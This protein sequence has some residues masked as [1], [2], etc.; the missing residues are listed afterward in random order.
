MKH[1]EY[2]KRDISALEREST[3]IFPHFMRALFCSSVKLFGSKRGI[4]FGLQVASMMAKEDPSGVQILTSANLSSAS[5][6]K[7][8]QSPFSRSRE[9]KKL[10]MTRS[11]N[12]CEASA[13][14]K[15]KVPCGQ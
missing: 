2:E 13:R 5:R 8:S 1:A 14:R 3:M 10:S 4:Q 15:P 11:K 7:F 12:L 9:L 6:N